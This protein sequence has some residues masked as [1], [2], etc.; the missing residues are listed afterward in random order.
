[1]NLFLVGLTYSECLKFRSGWRGCARKYRSTE[2]E[3]LDSDGFAVDKGGTFARGEIN[4]VVA[5]KAI[6]AEQ[7]QPNDARQN[8]VTSRF[9][10]I[11]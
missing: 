5:D 6:G 1:L 9:N 8:E 7:L 4:G 10:A 2:S 11:L 3:G